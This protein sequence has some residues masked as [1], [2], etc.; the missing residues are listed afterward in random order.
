MA[1]TSDKGGRF[2]GGIPRVPLSYCLGMV[3]FRLNGTTGRGRNWIA[4]L[5]LIA[6]SLL[7]SRLPLA[8]DL[9]VAF[10]INP[11]VSS[12]GSA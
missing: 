4:L 9:F 11:V 1:P 6:V 8:A 5:V 10:V 2:A 7:A 3:L 12:S